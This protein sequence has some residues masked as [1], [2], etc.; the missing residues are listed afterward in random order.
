[1]K[2]LLLSKAV[3]YASIG[4]IKCGWW[5]SGFQSMDR[6]VFIGGAS[7]SGT[8]L[9]TRLLSAH[10]ELYVGP[11]TG[12]FTGNRNVDHLT[13]VTKLP[14]EWLSA[15]LRKSCCQGDFIQRLMRRLAADAGKPRWG[16]KTPAN[17][18]HIERILQFFPNASLIHII[19]DGRDVA[20]SLRTHPEYVWSNGGH[21]CQS[22][23]RL[24]HS[25]V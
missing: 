21:V 4:R 25:M 15:V 16:E 10:P 23:V 6:P 3:N 12:I 20:C 2:P 22:V 9:L 1:M 14:N 5:S 17:I 24:H 19:R 8:T 11:E 18:R 7:R 13:R